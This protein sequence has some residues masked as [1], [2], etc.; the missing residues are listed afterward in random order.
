MDWDFKVSRAR[1]E[2][3]S[4][5]IFKDKMMKKIDASMTDYKTWYQ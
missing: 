3:F 5:D 1:A 4:V 2:E